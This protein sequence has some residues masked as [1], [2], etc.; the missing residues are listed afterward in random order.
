MLGLLKTRTQVFSRYW[1][2]GQERKG[3]DL[4]D[5]DDMYTGEKITIYTVGTV[6]LN[7]YE[8]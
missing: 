5:G 6:H 4:G 7:A 3:S 8:I 2:G 1:G